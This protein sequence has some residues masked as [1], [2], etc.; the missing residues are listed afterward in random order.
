LTYFTRASLRLASR[1]GHIER[2]AR[3]VDV[4]SHVLP[5]PVE[6]WFT[7]R[8]FGPTTAS[9]EDLVEL[10]RR[11]SLTVGVCLP[12]LNEEH[13]IGHICEVVARSLMPQGLVDKLVVVD[14]GSSDSTLEVAAAAGA[15]VHRAAELLADSD[16]SGGGGK[17]DALWRSL[18]V[19]PTDIV[20][21]IDSDTK[22]FHERFVTELLDPMLSDPQLMFAK[23]FYDRPI[24]SDGGTLTTGGARV[25]EIALR[26]LLQ[27]F[28]PELTGFVQPL[29]GEYAIRTELA[30]SLPFF[31]G[32]AVEIGLLIDVLETVG[33][34]AMCQVDLGMRVHRNRD[35]LSLGRTSFQVM[36]ALLLRA[37]SSGRLKLIDELP[38]QLIQFR[39][40][41][42]GPTPEARTLA[43]AERPPLI[44]LLQ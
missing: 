27:F 11:R 35:V 1:A 19:L 23:A 24:E 30:R 20:V 3:L 44:S 29:S 6:R 4:T 22:N 2:G 40:S 33:L 16:L 8:T 10:K 39:S 5:D 42:H 32:Y 18:S 26:P 28:Y 15:E 7:R 12:A 37:E 34:D 36:Q 14:S 25:T 21:W 41:D 13:T 31:T 43:I 38:D 9:L 17:G